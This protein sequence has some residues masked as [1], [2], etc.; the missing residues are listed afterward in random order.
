MDLAGYRKVLEK[1]TIF[2]RQAV[3][4]VGRE[5]LEE[6]KAVSQIQDTQEAQRIVQGIAQL[7]QQQIHSQISSVVTRCLNVVFAEDPYVFRIEFE[8]KRGKTEAKIVFERGGVVLDDPLNEVGGGVLD[9]ASLA[10][11]LSSILLSRPPMRRLLVLDEPFSDIRGGEY[12]ARTREMLLKL[13]QELGV[14]IIINTDIPEYAMGTV[15]EFPREST[16]TP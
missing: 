3:D 10:L 4:S 5:E 9:V 12:R 8:Q 7:I 13:S 14:Q 16:T 2:Y 1:Q 6:K 11:R 15:V